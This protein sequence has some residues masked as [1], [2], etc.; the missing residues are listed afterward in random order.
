M[1]QN[2][3]N[4][5]SNNSVEK[6]KKQRKINVFALLLGILVIATLLTYI[7]PAGDYARVEQNGRTVVD[8]GSFKWT[9]STPVG[10]FD[11]VKAVHTG[12]VEAAN[13]IFF[14]LIIGGF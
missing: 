11:M 6:Q 8:P 2:V 12:M 13:I 7:V 1:S 14:V 9:D 3:R 10:P 4:I 5:V